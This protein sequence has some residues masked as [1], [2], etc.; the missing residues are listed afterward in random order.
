[1]FKRIVS[2]ALVAL[3]FGVAGPVPA[4][5]ASKAEKEAQTSQGLNPRSEGGF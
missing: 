1:M 4:R 2:L 3:L 5:A